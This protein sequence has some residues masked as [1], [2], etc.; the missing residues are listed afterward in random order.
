MTTAPRI[1]TVH[2]ADGVQYSRLDGVLHVETLD[3]LEINIL[4]DRH[5]FGHSPWCTGRR[6]FRGHA[7]WLSLPACM[8]CGFAEQSAVDQLL[9]D[10]IGHPRVAPDYI[11]DMQ[12][13]W[14]VV[15]AMRSQ[16]KATQICF[17][18]HTAAP[19]RGL[20]QLI[21]EL[22]PRIVAIAALKAV[23]IIDVDGFVRE[24]PRR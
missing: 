11:R 6:R 1:I 17:M 13:V 7:G 9:T 10:D 21:F 23:G 22:T 15:D 12:S 18:L 24:E 14:P 2:S 5:V 19:L 8:L 20:Q 16:D 4:L 3:N